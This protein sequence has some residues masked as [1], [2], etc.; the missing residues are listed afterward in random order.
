MIS[1]PLSSPF[2]SEAPAHACPPRVRPHRPATGAC[3]DPLVRSHLP[4]GLRAV[5]VAGGAARASA[6]IRGAR[7]DTTRRRGLVVLRRDG[8]RDRRP[9]GLCA[10]LQVGG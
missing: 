10:V 1:A 7:L 4:G 8:R 3:R 5:P 2:I 9:P 6:A